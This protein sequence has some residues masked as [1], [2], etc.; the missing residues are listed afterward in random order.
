MQKQSQTTLIEKLENGETINFLPPYTFNTIESLPILITVGAS[1][2]AITTLGIYGIV[3]LAELNF[4]KYYLLI[5]PIVSFA[6]VYI[7][8]WINKNNYHKQLL[9][10]SKEGCRYKDT[11]F[12]WNSVRQ[13]S[14][15]SIDPESN[16]YQFN[17]LTQKTHVSF[18]ISGENRDSLGLVLEK[19]AQL[20]RSTVVDHRFPFFQWVK[21]GWNFQ[22]ITWR[23]KL[24]NFWQ[25]LVR[26]KL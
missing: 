26:W 1:S 5:A 16:L 7:F 2:L 22:P 17:I 25:S 3:S 10:L 13:A 24:T 11:F 14:S 23:D 8:Y 4:S 21:K 20:E 18:R 15:N 6:I 9:V 12:S 19:Y